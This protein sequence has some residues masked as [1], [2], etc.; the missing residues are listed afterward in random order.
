MKLQVAIR[1]FLEDAELAG[2]KK[3]KTLENYEHYLNRFW[4]FA[5]DI[6]V[7]KIDDALIKNY[8]LHLNRFN[9][10]TLSKNTQNFHLVALR[11]FLA[12][13]SRKN[14]QSLSP[15]K[16]D[17]PGVEQVQVEFLDEASLETLLALPK[18]NT[19][20][21]KRDLAILEILFSTG[22]RV[23]ELVSLKVSDIKGGDEIPILGK[24]GKRRVVFLSDNSKKALEVYLASHP[25]KSEALF[26]SKFQPEKPL[27]ARSVQRI[28]QKYAQLAGLSEKVTPHTLRHTFATD[29]LKSGA[30][31]RAVQ[32]LLGHSSVTTTQRYTHVTD[33]HLK[34]VHSA[35]H[36]R[37]KKAEDK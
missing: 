32:A 26:V 36:G 25:S 7:S 13:L 34:E 4:D 15:E 10:G 14:I 11:A 2:G 33:K 16:V 23:S 3:P 30:D 24:G 18:I 17:L 1:D 19:F 31:L 27:T 12:F 8:R 35:F 5:G 28:V 37:R 21:G 9:K 22:M 29:L 6:S 20:I